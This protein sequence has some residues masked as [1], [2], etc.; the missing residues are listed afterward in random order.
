MGCTFRFCEIILKEEAELLGENNPETPSHPKS[1]PEVHAEAEAE[2]EEP[3]DVSKSNKTDQQPGAQTNNPTDEKGFQ[4]DADKEA[5]EAPMEVDDEDPDVF[6]PFSESQLR[7]N[8]QNDADQGYYN[9]FQD[10]MT[11]L[12]TAIGRLNFDNLFILI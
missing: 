11:M 4:N 5:P 2:V 10:N 6:G 7:P 9:A 3:L 12:K 8:I 1:L